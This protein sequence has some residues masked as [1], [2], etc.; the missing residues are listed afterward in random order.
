MNPVELFYMFG[1]SF[2]HLVEVFGN[3]G[4]STRSGHRPSTLNFETSVLDK[5]NKPGE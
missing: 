4:D 3:L 5:G 2:C 1:R